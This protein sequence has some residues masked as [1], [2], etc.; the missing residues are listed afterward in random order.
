TGEVP[1]PHPGSRARLLPQRLPPP[2]GAERLPPHP[3]PPQSLLFL[4]LVAAV[5]L[6]LN[7]LF[8]TAYL[9]CLCCCKRDEEPETKRPHSCCVT[10]MAV[11][12]GLICW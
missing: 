6:G 7:L 1:R 10:W 8:L 3:F 5:C 9:I 12:A 11:T 2:R 4:G